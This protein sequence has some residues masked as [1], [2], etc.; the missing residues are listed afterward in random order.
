MFGEIELRASGRW[1]VRF[2]GP[3]GKRYTAGHTFTT[4][5]DAEA[6]C[7]RE[8]RLCEDPDAWLPPAV[9][10]Q[11]AREQRVTFSE[12]AETFM[13]RRRLAPRT[14]AEYENYLA[15]HLI[16]AFGDR[17]L[18]ELDATSVGN[19]HLSMDPAKA[20]WRSRVYGLLRTIMGEAARDGLVPGNPVH[21]RGAS[22]VKRKRDV[23]VLTS[24]QLTRLVEEMPAKHRA[25]VLLAVTC[26][27]RFG[28]LTELRRKDLDLATR[29][30][31]V[32]RGVTHPKGG[33]F[34]GPPKTAAGIRDVAIPPH[35]IPVLR[36]HVE[37]HAAWG[38]DGLI[39]PSDRDANTHLRQ[40]TLA[41]RKPR[42]INATRTS[43]EHVKPGR[44][45]Y[46]AA[47]S[48]GVPDLRWHDLRHTGAVLAAHN[49]ATT[50]D[51]M[52]RLGHSTA[53]AA[54]IYQHAVSSRDQ[55]LAAAISASMT[56]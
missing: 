26:G 52:H 31:K 3:D 13:A 50:A 1:S 33:P 5:G 7:A 36:T 55:E 43:P 42:V 28:E 41:G 16:P 32:R 19:W 40:S 56:G 24:E 34:V 48:A 37:Q 18:T 2:T 46:A 9:R 20:T 6:W 39:F 25:L 15:R 51:L 17:P 27:L 45:F 30:V 35:L 47:D 12:Y 22:N 29:V 14:R 11:R 21:I 44:G 23:L 8:Q 54:M 38:R 10:R 53:A 4:K 49:G